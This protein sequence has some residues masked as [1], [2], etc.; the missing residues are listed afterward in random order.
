[1]RGD[2]KMTIAERIVRIAENDKR[3]EERINKE[4]DS[5]KMA[6]KIKD[7]EGNIFCFGGLENGHPWYRG[8]GGSTHIFA[9]NGYEV[10]EQHIKM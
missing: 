9:L 10:I 5:C 3:I 8:I 4:I 1:M 6:Y 2:K 7:L